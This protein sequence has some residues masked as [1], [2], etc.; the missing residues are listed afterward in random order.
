MCDRIREECEVFIRQNH[1]RFC[2]EKEPTLSP[3]S[4]RSRFKAYR[5]D[6]LSERVLDFGM[7]IHFAVEKCDPDPL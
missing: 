6:D 5:V 1:C 4:R 2:F 7:L 3:K